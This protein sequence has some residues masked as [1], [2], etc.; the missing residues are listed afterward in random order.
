MCPRD[1]F[2]PDEEDMCLPLMSPGSTCQLNR[3]DQC[4]P[5]SDRAELDDGFLTNRGAMCFKYQCQYANI[6]LGQSCEVENTVYVGYAGGGQQFYNIISRDRCAPKLWCNVMSGVCEPKV[7]LGAA[8]SA[9]KQCESLIVA[10]SVMI[11]TSVALFMTHTRSRAR[12]L[13][14]I[15][16]YFR[17]QTSYRNSIISMHTTAR[18][19]LPTQSWSP[20]RDSLSQFGAGTRE[21]YEDDEDSDRRGLLARRTSDE[22]PEH[23]QD[24]DDEGVGY[25][26]TPHGSSN[27]AP[28]RPPRYSTGSWNASEWG[29]KR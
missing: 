27:S 9:H 25:V 10:F 4:Q 3:D 28:A 2:C 18:S 7:P 22:H 24:S 20:N 16:A 11:G 23:Q 17:E 14:E 5:P 15:R 19:R 29:M 13:R 12:K 26:H 21:S 8:C 1:Q 6:T